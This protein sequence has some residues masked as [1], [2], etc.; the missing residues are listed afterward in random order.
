M[1][2]APDESPYLAPYRRAAERHG[3]DF[4]SLLWAST[5]TQEVRFD[6]ICR[7]APLGG[8]SVLDAG[9]GRADLLRFLLSRGV[10]PADYNGIEAVHELATAAGRACERAG[11]VPARITRADFVREPLR[12]FVGADL[13]VFSGS[14][15][16]IDDGPFY[17]TIR[18][19]FDAA[20]ETLVFNFLSSNYLA[21]AA[22]LRW[23]RPAS[24]LRF[25]ADLTGDVKSLDDYLH[26]DCTVALFKSDHP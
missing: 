15:N 10:R 2:S 5:H 12:L 21:G 13:V 23:R 24:V 25:C 19:A 6:A 8:R 11:A 16:T 9:C 1:K 14:L 20:A 7:L 26:G 4:P 17:A 22:Y 18:R 3:A